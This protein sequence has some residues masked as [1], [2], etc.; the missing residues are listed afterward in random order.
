M[1]GIGL[2]SCIPYFYISERE[3]LFQS[4]CCSL[5]LRTHTGGFY[6]AT[7]ILRGLISSNSQLCLSTLKKFL[8]CWKYTF[9]HRSLPVPVRQTLIAHFI[10]LMIHI[11]YF[12]LLWLPWD[13]FKLLKGSTWKPQLIWKTKFKIA[14]RVGVI[15]SKKY[16]CTQ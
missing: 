12:N 2:I 7:T 5:F 8:N 6:L 14:N 16:L 4:F 11:S 9:D 10:F 15:F 1:K 13:L 3:D